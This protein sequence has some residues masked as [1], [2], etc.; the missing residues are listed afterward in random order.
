MK[1]SELINELTKVL[2]EKGDLYIYSY[3]SCEE[4]TAI[5][6][7]IKVI[8]A[9]E[10]AEDCYCKGNNWIEYDIEEKVLKNTDNIV[11]IEEN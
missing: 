3:N 2:N 7:K 5:P 1:V 10:G 11:L 9:V 8:K 4:C 6:R